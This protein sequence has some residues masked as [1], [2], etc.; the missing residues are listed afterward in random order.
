MSDTKDLIKI[1]NRIEADLLAAEREMKR[2][3]EDK[4]D[5]RGRLKATQ[6]L[7]LVMQLEALR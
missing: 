7:A 5:L 4:I 3:E 6:E 1:C 2:L